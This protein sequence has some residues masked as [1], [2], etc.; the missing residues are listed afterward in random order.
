M[1][2]AV[3]INNFW[4][5]FG[6]P[7]YPSTSVPQKSE[8]PYL[9][10]EVVNGDFGEDVLSVVNTYHRT[11][12]ESKPNELVRKIKAK[13]GNGG[14]AIKYDGGAIWIKSGSPFAQAIP[15][16]DKAVKRRYINVVYQYLGG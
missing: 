12:S 11:S 2:D 16:E 1:N 7:A 3:A 6:I 15:D 5:S 9:T 8:Y 14:T 4:N 13:V 10:Y